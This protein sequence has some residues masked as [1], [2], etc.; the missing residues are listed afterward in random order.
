MALPNSAQLAF[1]LEGMGHGAFIA[2]FATAGNIIITDFAI[3]TPSTVIEQK[4][5]IGAPLKQAGITGFVTWTA[6]A[7]TLVTQGTNPVTNPVI[8]KQ[9]DEFTE[10]YENRIC[11]VAEV[12]ETYRA[13][14]FWTQS[15]RGR[16]SL[17]GV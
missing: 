7:Q 13:G 14:E 3:N 16:I 9:G 10:P 11:W 17:S 1:Y 12:D 6:T 5:Q 8:I 4:N 15:I 2:A